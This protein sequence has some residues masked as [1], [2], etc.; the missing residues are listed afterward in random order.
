M[1]RAY[2]W[3]YWQEFYLEMHRNIFRQNKII[4]YLD[5]MQLEMTLLLEQF[6]PKITNHLH[7]LL[8]NISSYTYEI[9]DQPGKEF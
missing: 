8:A 7:L 4:D 6:Y 9:H 2:G 1:C 5:K 3:K